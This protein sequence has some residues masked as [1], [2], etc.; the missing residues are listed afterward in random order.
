MLKKERRQ[1]LFLILFLNIQSK[2]ESCPAACMCYS[3]PRTTVSCQQQGI[4]NIPTGIPTQSQRIFL[5]NNK[6][7]LVR[8]TS[9]SFCYNLTVLLLF[10]NNISV[11][12]PRAFHG[13]D[14]LEELDIADN[15]NLRSIS[16]A[17]FRSLT[18]L[19][20]LNLHRCSLSELPVGLFQGLSSLQYLYL[21][22]NTLQSL[23]DDIF[24]DLGNLTYLFLHGN[25]IKSLS[26]NSF[27][28]LG[29]LDRLL[30]HQN[31]ISV[32]HRRSFHDLG[33]LVTLYLF[34]NNLTV[35]TGET[36]DPLVSLQYLRLNGNQ[37]ICDC[38]AQSLW[39]W[40]KRFKGS[41]SDLE[42]HV[43]AT[44]A[45]EDLKRLPSMALDGCLDSSSQIRTSVFR[46]KTR[47]GTLPTVEGP[48]MS[49]EG[50]QLCCQMDNDKSSIYDTKVKTEPSSFNSRQTPSS[51]HKK[52]NIS[53]TKNL[54]S[55]H[56]KNGTYKQKL[57]DAPVGTLSGNLDK[58]FDKLKPEIIHKLEP[59]IAP[60][61]KRRKCPKKP[62]SESQCRLSQQT[63]CSPLHL[64]FSLLVVAWVSFLVT[65]C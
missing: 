54:G 19:H 27:R 29:N 57:N 12:E 43:P 2:V 51:P 59:S 42:C 56:S 10:S 25:K 22:D 4:L 52:E 63:N 24:V 53:K 60:T 33:K 8:S 36:M 21:Q 20:T 6:I 11:I 47:L 44:L 62:R 37:W 38:R 65:F 32:V 15:V 26:E 31:R 23:H 9:F 40:F 5:Q 41:S 34:N 55:D 30:L 7:T 46:T 3:E 35:L 58:S 28:G 39:D 14:K 18:H 61:K 50:S 16:P 64:S 13:L 17:T 49:K 1:V 45:G 48:L